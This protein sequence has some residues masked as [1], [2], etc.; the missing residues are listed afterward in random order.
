MNIFSIRSQIMVKID[1]LYLVLGKSFWTTNFCEFLREDAAATPE[2]QEERN[3]FCKIS[4]D[5]I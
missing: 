2:T 5:N 4:L 1:T 3:I